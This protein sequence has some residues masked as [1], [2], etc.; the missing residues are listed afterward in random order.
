MGSSMIIKTKFNVPAV[1]NKIVQRK[2]LTQK[3]QPITDYK[4]VLVTAPAGYGKTTAAAVSL[5]NT[6]VR[7]AWLSLDENDNDPVVFWR[8]LVAALGSAL[9]NADAAMDIIVNKGLISS[10][11]LAELLVN[12]LYGIPGHMLIILDDY[13]LIHDELIQKSMATFLKYLPNNITVIILSRTEPDYHLTGKHARGKVLKVG[14]ADL[15]FTSEETAEFFIKR[16]LALQPDDISILQEYT[17]GWPAGLVVAA[18]SIESSQDLDS[19]ITQFSGRNRYIDSF[20]RD[21]IF[22]N[23]ADE[24][25]SFLIETSFLDKLCAD[26]CYA[27]TGNEEAGQ[28]LQSLAEGNS[29]VFHLDSE[30]QWFR[31]HHL[32]KEFLADKLNEKGSD[33]LKD[34]YQKAGLWFKENEYWREA[35]EAFLKAGNYLEA[36]ILLV[37]PNIYMEMA[38]N[39]ELEEWCRLAASI[40]EGLPEGFL[41]EKV[42][43]YCAIAWHL[44]MENSLDDARGWIDKAQALVETIEDQNEKEKGYLQAHVD[45]TRVSVSVVQL[46]INQVRYYSKQLLDTELYQPLLLGEI[47]T[48]VPA[49]LDTVYGF[50][51]RLNQIDQSWSYLMADLPRIVGDFS[52]YATI[53]M[54]ECLYERNDLE[55]VY[56]TM[57]PGMESIIELNNPGAI[58]P[59][60]IA[61]ARLK[62]AQG[63]MPGAFDTIAAGRGKLRGKNQAFWNY[64]FNIMTASFFIDLQEAASAEEWLDIGRISIY[65]SLSS[66]RELEYITLARYL[67][68]QRQYDDALLLLN[69]LESFAAREN[70]L[71][72]QIRALSLLAV[73]HYSRG[74]LPNAMLAMEKALELG[75]EHGYTRTFIDQLEPMA[76]LLTEYCR[77]KERT[78][79]DE[80]HR[81][82]ITL[83]RLVREYIEKFRACNPNLLVK[84][85]MAEALSP[86]E[87]K[88]LQ[89]LAAERSNKEIAAELG[90][91]VRTVKYHNSRI[92]EKLT[93][94]NRFEAIIKARETGMLN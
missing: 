45:M 66:Y 91:T 18:L 67:S 82:A 71:A 92:F 59:C 55:A 2:N 4:L 7:H 21:E 53:I 80:K 86:R 26:L 73:S 19:A 1:N 27:V 77:W 17:E 20:I 56:Q 90:I 51:G 14:P 29:L 93:V 25:K 35:I 31:Y 34:L 11:L 32:F 81:Y 24:I 89:L 3:L 15:S 70:H 12:Q 10:G 87:Y 16:G 13:H 38:Q 23:W 78:A 76:E 30:N 58:V 9:N 46:D 8:Y 22:N 68:L 41:K 62:R 28:V 65:D 47:N 79:E 88:V 84:D 52:A 36:F 69:R 50:K 64:H 48:G 33:F 44:S 42:Q 40:P 39:R 72:G 94:N 5:W 54:A 57:L 60:F 74:D 75:M 43:T 63:D 37:D 49:M 83:S 61:L 85:M 6:G